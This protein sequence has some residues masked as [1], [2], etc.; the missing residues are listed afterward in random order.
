MEKEKF[1]EPTIEEA[2]AEGMIRNAM[3]ELKNL[4]ENS[5]SDLGVIKTGADHLK[6][7][8]ESYPDKDDIFFT[9]ARTEVENLI[10]QASER[11]ES[12]FNA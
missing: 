3:L 7:L 6:E 2:G 9:S 8:F 10:K 1:I 5:D 11:V 4:L 12:R